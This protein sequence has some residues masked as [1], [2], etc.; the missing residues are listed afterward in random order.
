MEATHQEAGPKSRKPGFFFFFN[1]ATTIPA[2]DSKPLDFS[3]VRE[4]QTSVI[5]DVLLDALELNPN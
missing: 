2:L 3:Y 4:N 5:L 1:S